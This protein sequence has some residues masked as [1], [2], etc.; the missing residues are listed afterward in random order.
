M[1]D[2]IK[3]YFDSDSTLVEACLQSDSR[4]QSYLY[5]EYSKSMF[6]LCL[7]MMSNR[8]D[9][10]DVFQNAFIVVFSKLNSYKSKSPLKYWIK[11]IFVNHCINELKRRK[12]F[13]DLEES[14]M[15]LIESDVEIEYSSKSIKKGITLLPAGY[16]TVLNLYLFEGYNHIEI[17]EI[18]GISD[19]TSKS[20]YSRAKT[21]LRHLLLK[22]KSE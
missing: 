11:R 20:Q 22:N 13:V 19:S 14:K 7:R 9:A 6:G 3:K 12:E 17:G 15:V 21:K 1:K 18:L 4:A 16:R 5:G 8:Q 10:E 2:T